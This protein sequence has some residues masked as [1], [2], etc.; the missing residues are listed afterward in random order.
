M[1]CDAWYYCGMATKKKRKVS[2]IV[3]PPVDVDRAFKAKLIR[4]GKAQGLALAAFVR[5]L[6]V[7]HPKLK[8]LSSPA[9]LSKKD[10]RHVELAKRVIYRWGDEELREVLDATGLGNHPAVI[11]I[12][13]RIGEEMNKDE[14]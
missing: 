10:A 9:A 2:R 4:L 12:F 5:H 1:R 8:G 7:T 3:L 14:L 13:G 6:L 11:R